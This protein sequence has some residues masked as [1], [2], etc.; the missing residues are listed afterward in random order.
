MK[1]PP[2]IP[3]HKEEKV[4]EMVKV[5]LQADKPVTESEIAEAVGYTRQGVSNYR[6]ELKLN[7]NIHH[8][9]IGGA[10]AYYNLPHYGPKTLDSYVDV[11]DM[12]TGEKIT[13]SVS[14][15]NLNGPVS[16]IGMDT[17]STW[18]KLKRKLISYI[19]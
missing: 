3:A 11:E 19:G 5:V 1:N 16:K 9:M 7:E 8:D 18:E 12:V 15:K 13:A 10:N 6:E 2:D 4:E 17:N 14:K